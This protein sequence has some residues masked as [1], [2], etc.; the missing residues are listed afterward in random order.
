[1]Q[2]NEMSKNNGKDKRSFLKK[3]RNQYRWMLL[4]FTDN[5]VIIAHIHTHLPCSCLVSV[6]QQLK[7][8]SKP[9]LKQV[10]EHQMQKNGNIGS[11]KTKVCHACK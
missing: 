9:K 1:M 6:R 11:N 5:L 7:L 10:F 4:L 8:A 3:G 2:E